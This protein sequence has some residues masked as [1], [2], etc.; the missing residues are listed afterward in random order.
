[1]TRLLC[2]LVWTLSAAAPADAA[3]S[4]GASAAMGPSEQLQVVYAHDAAKPTH[5]VH[6]TTRDGGATWTTQQITQTPEAVSSDGENRPKIAL[7]ARGETYVSWT[8]PT[9][10][11][12]TADIRFARSLDGGKS[13]SAPV[14][15]HKD[16]QQIAH[17]FDSMVVDG[18]GRVWVVW[19][20][21]RDLEVAQQAGKKYVGA[22]LY[23]AYSAD[24]GATWRGDFKLAEHACECCRIALSV[25]PQGQPLVMWRHV[26][27][28]GER[29]HALAVLQDDA[30]PKIER[31]THE[32][33]K[34]DACPHHGPGLAFTPDGAAH[35]VWFNQRDGEGRVFY[36]RLPAQPQHTRALPLGAA[37]ADL[38]V[39]NEV[40]AIVWK[41]HDG[42]ATRVESWLSTDGGAS[43]T[44]GPAFTTRGESDQPRLVA[45]PRGPTLV[46]RREE[47]IA[48]EPLTAGT[49]AQRPSAPRRDASLGRQQS[50]GMRGFTR[51]TMAQIERDHAKQSFW[52]LL[53]DLECGYC[54]QS[55]QNLAAAQ[56]QDPSIRAVTIAT[57]NIQHADELQRRLKEFGVKTHDY[58]FAEGASDALRHA[59]D[60]TWA[61]EKPRAYRYARGERVEA[62]SG[63]ISS[64]QFMSIKPRR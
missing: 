48:V 4:L 30:P 15:V 18:A 3:G 43:F 11:R 1:M 58:A 31:A 12:Y 14:T 7:G 53:W 5:L 50:A 35:A 40:L 54:M 52:V 23:Y 27:A 44:D 34:V 45:T 32:R 55:L 51:Q 60:P 10:T 19:V 61:G 47:G 63:V 29:D 62:I 6:A 26:F 24:H 8:S 38:I 42:E 33:W 59:I 28:G 56:R 57:D 20:D 37:H 22:A 49:Q 46:W 64:E 21:K 39:Q 41:R 2:L 9:S 16:R 25:N 36:G 13:W 17:R